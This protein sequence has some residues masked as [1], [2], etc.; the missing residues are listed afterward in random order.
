MSME[1]T[2]RRFI[3]VLFAAIIASVAVVPVIGAPSS[4]LWGGVI[5]G[6][7]V[8]FVLEIFEW[9]VSRR[10][11]NVKAYDVVLFSIAGIVSNAFLLGFVQGFM[12]GSLSVYASG[13]A[14]FIALYIIEWLAKTAKH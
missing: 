9:A 11:F 10:G 12:K 6:L 1:N 7:A 3:L 2:A 8:Y 14:F 5:L 13:V 4:V